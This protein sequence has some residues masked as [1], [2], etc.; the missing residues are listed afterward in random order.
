MD[1]KSG[2]NSAYAG[3]WVALVRGKIV[4]QG[5]TQEQVFQIARHSRSKEEVTTRFMPLIPFSSPLLDSIQPLLPPDEPVYLVGGAVRDAVLG[6]VSRDLDFACPKGI[7]LAKKVADGLKAAFFPLDETFDT[8]RVISQL[9]DGSRDSLDFAGFRGET[10]EADLRGRDF[11]IN[12]V[13]MDMRSGEI[14]DP[15]GGIRDIREK[16]IKVCSEDAFIT[17]PVRILR[18]VRLAAG[19]GFTISPDTRNLMKTAVSLLPKVS[20]ERQRDEFFKILSGPKPDMSIRALELLGVL[21]A[22]LPELDSL[23]GVEQTAPHVHDVWVHTLAVLRHLENILDVL[24]PK[25]DEQ[26]ANSDLMNGLLVLKLG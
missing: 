19:L 3:R 4:A 21:P 16:S 7:K 9:P 6:I 17:D 8:A 12:A 20:P 24:A 26:K 14:I 18:A 1:K 15:L 11:T 13:A 10:L 25:Y 22:F 5:D 23:K 2:L